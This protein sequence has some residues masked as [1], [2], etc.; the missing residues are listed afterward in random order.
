[1][2]NFVSYKG[3][4]YKI[5]VAHLDKLHFYHESIIYQVYINIEEFGNKRNKF[6]ES[7]LFIADNATEEQM[8][9]RTLFKN[10]LESTD[11]YA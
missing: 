9:A 4:V 2:L 1:M 8:I 11:F 7:A 6:F 10:T 5:N 3:A